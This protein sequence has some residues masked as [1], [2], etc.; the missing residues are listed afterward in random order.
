MISSRLVPDRLS[1][2]LVTLPSLDIERS[3]GLQP[4]SNPRQIKGQQ[5]SRQKLKKGAQKNSHTTCVMIFFRNQSVQKLLALRIHIQ[6]LLK[7][8][9]FSHLS[10][11]YN[12]S[13]C[14]LAMIY[15]VSKAPQKFHFWLSIELAWQPVT[16]R[17][18]CKTGP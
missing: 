10:E 17:F 18:A 14:N 8:S 6:S 15:A 4:L 1:T 2:R 5:R 9:C 16:A 11:R 13:G 12:I 7:N 3:W